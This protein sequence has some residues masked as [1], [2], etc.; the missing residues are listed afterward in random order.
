VRQTESYRGEGRRRSPS[1]WDGRRAS[2]EPTTVLW[3]WAEQDG[4]RGAGAQ[5]SVDLE[6]GDRG[7]S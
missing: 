2:H 3:P 4:V 5:C 7:V 1:G 6:R